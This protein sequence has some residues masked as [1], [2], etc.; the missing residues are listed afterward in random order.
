MRRMIVLFML[1]ISALPASAQS[2]TLAHRLPVPL[3]GP[4]STLSPDGV[5]L[6]VFENPV[7]VQNAVT[8]LNAP[9]YLVDVVQGELVGMLGGVQSDLASDVAFSPDGASLASIHTNGQLII[10]DIASRTA[11]ADYD[12]LPIGGS[13]VDFMPDGKTLILL[14][15]TGA[16]GQQ[17]FFDL[18]TGSITNILS[19]M[20][21][22]YL[23]FLDTSSDMAVRGSRSFAAQ[24]ILPTGEI[25]AA[26]Q[27]GEVLIWNT[28]LRTPIT[29]QPPAEEGPMRFNVR[30]LQVM[31]D[32]A[33]FFYDS[34][35]E[36][37]V[38][39]TADR[40]RVEY[41]FGAYAS[42]LSEDGRLAYYD[43]EAE[44]FFVADLTQDSPEPQP[45]Q[46]DL[47]DLDANPQISL[48]F[49]ANGYL[50]I[51]GFLNLDSE[52]AILVVDL[53]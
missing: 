42:A 30:R 49:A 14:Y 21:D 35:A 31:N 3:A 44:Q 4:Q 7:V 18:E 8:L 37:S 52:N 6:A 17:M 5:T 47:G 11:L 15:N 33:I 23:E 16:F 20:P 12:W 48:S 50:V 51:S 25:V 39:L 43:R 40:Q 45:I 2:T 34:D 19:I 27:N 22:T 29:I 32:G 41:S 1:L 53:G 10:W 36:L 13:R 38:L 9:I 26:T 24:A 46:L 28:A